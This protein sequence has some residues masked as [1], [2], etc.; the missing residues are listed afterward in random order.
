MRIAEI[1]HITPKGLETRYRIVA[2][3]ADLVLARGAQGTSLDDICAATTT[4]K[5]Q[6]FHYFPGGKRDLVA[7]IAAFQAARVLDAQRPYLDSLAT[8]GGLGRVAATHVL[9]HY[10]SEPA[11]GC[12]IGA[13]SAET[14]S[15]APEL[16]AELQAHMDTWRRYL[17]RGVR[18]MRARGTLSADASPRALSLGIF[19][20]LHGGLAMMRTTESITPLAAALDVGI[21]ARC[22]RRE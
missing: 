4:S 2:A 20:A 11:W 12:P 1:G 3:A 9:R 10:S 7:A 6:L 17:E 21:A 8:W 5:S 14:A 18:R 16:A 15:G 13:L 19:A 22:T